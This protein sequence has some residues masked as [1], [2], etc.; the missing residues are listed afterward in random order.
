MFFLKPF[1]PPMI[2]PNLLT[3]SL[4][5]VF[6]SVVIINVLLSIGGAIQYL[7]SVSSNCV[8]IFQNLLPRILLLQVKTQIQL[9]VA[10]PQWSYILKS[11]YEI[12][13][14]LTYSLLWH[15]NLILLIYHYTLK[16]NIPDTIS[17]QQTL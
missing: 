4:N 14:V 12:H 5:S 1:S 13:V 10:S 11:S 6:F 9:F 3:D 16:R 7:S 2:C 17:D 8:Q 15:R